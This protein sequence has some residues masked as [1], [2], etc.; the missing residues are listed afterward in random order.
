M[1]EAASSDEAT[2]AAVLAAYREA[3]E[4]QKDVSKCYGCRS[5]YLD[6]LPS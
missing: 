3:R 1:D 4:A 6:F 2:L 5:Q